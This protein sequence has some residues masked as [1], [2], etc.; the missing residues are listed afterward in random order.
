MTPQRWPEINR[1]RL[2]AV[3][4]SDAY[5]SEFGAKLVEW[6]GGRAAPNRPVSDR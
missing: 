3:F 6:D 5:L 2:E 4:Q 1:S